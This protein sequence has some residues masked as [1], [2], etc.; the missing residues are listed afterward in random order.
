VTRRVVPPGH[1][2]MQRKQLLGIA[3]RAEL[4]AGV[5]RPALVL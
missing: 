1:F 2:V 5:R 4:A 3:R